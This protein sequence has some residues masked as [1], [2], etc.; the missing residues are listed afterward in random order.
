MLQMVYN[1]GNGLITY[2][3]SMKFKKQ[4]SKNNYNYNN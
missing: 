2:E 1:K 3:A 4:S